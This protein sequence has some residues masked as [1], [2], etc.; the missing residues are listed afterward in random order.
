[1]SYEDHAFGRNG[2]TVITTTA[3][4]TTGPFEAILVTSD[5]VFNAATV[6]HASYNNT[7]AISS[8]TVVPAGAVL[9]GFWDEIK[10]DSGEVM[11]YKRSAGSVN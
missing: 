1:M 10:L 11:A 6:E 9:F 8:L 3:V 5:A 7:G 2:Y 4:T